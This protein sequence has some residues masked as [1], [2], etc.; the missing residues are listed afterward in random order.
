MDFFDQE[1]FGRIPEGNILVKIGKAV[2]FESVA[3][4]LE[5]YYDK[6]QG[7]PSWPIA[8]MVKALFLSLYFF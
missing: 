4:G 1:I 8:T 6:D 3:V 7:R 2:D 5:C